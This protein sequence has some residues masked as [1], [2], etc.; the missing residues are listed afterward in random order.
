MSETR[1]RKANEAI[2]AL[3]R[4]VEKFP[5]CFFFYEHARRPLKVGLHDDLTAAGC[6]SADLK[7]A[8]RRYTNSFGYLRS[9]KTGAAR[10]DLT[11]APAGEVTAEQA[12]VAAQ[13][14]ADQKL[15]L[16]RR[17]EHQAKAS[18]KMTK[19]APNPAPG[20]ITLAGLREAATARKARAA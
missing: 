14:L 7:I 19:P 3:G 15:K 13:K 20:R 2:A 1:L 16:R 9:L 4:L 5:N 8:L 10:L 12:A 6:P 17:Q 18:A 11:G